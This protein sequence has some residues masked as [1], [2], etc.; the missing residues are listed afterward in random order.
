MPAE[1]L[2]LCDV[3]PIGFSNHSD[4]RLD[5]AIGAGGV[6]AATG[7]AG[8]L[9]PAAGAKVLEGRGLYLS[10]GW[11][12]LH[13]HIWHGGTDISIRPR[14]CGLVRGV[15]TLVDAGSAGCLVNVIG[16]DEVV[17]EQL[18]PGCANARLTGKVDDDVDA[19]E[20]GKDRLKIG[21]IADDAF[22]VLGSSGHKRDV[23]ALREEFPH[24]PADLAFRAGDQH[25]LSLLRHG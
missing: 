21:D 20:G 23:V 16:A 7:P 3:R 18:F 15:T 17:R 9:N 24:R 22:E 6:I 11:T 25:V 8:S 12:D 13:V 19:F 4:A 5:V 2:F 1:G 10:P 14:E